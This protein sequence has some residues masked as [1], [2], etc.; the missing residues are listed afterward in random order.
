MRI[1][2]LGVLAAT[3]LIASAAAQSRMFVV[4]F[5]TDEDRLTV[6]AEKVVS[7][8]AASAKETRGASVVV[9]GYGDD[10]HG[11]DKELAERRASAVVRALEAAGVAQNRIETRPGAPPAE[12][13]GIPVH[14]VTVT[15][16]GR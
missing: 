14:K 12:A 15:L 6:E 8:I 13:T 9:A 5:G 11:R 2:L 3:L 4:F 16:E 7:E 1:L 10:D